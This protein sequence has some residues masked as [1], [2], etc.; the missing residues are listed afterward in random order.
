MPVRLGLPVPLGPPLPA[1]STVPAT[2]QPRI[3]GSFNPNISPNPSRIFQSTGFTAA[4]FTFTNTWFSPGFGRSTSASSTT[5][6]F[7][8]R[9]IRT[10]FMI[11]PP[12]LGQFGLLKH[13]SG[14]ADGQATIARQHAQIALH[15][16][17]LLMHSP[18]EIRT[19]GLRPRTFYDL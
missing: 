13:D 18:I 4:A 3:S 15:H 12:V 1:I 8:Y 9:S 17:P 10:A 16:R 7:P 19:L 2:S 5:S 11:F 14:L 6:S